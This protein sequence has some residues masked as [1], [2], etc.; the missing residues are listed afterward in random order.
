MYMKLSNKTLNF[1]TETESYGN[2]SNKAIIIGKDTF[3]DILPFLATETIRK[4]LDIEEPSELTPEVQGILEYAE[5]IGV[6]EDYI[7]KL[8]SKYLKSFLS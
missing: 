3:P 5:M 6:N 7:T 1:I 2:L 8:Y 4:A